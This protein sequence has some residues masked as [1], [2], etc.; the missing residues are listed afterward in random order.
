M[1]RNLIFFAGLLG[2]AWINRPSAPRGSRIYLFLAALCAGVCA[3]SAQGLP[4][5]LALTVSVDTNGVV[6]APTNFW[7]VN[8]N[9]MASAIS[10][11]SFSTNAFSVSGT[12][13]SLAPTEY[14]SADR[15]IDGGAPT[16][17]FTIQDIAAMSLEG[18]TASLSGQS[19][20]TLDGQQSLEIF[21]R[22]NLY[23][24]TPKAW[25]LEASGNDT[26][27]LVDASTGAVEYTTRDPA[28]V[29]ALKALAAS[30]YTDGAI[31]RTRGYYTAGDGGGATYRYSAS[32]SDAEDGAITLAP[33]HGTGRFKLVHDGRVSLKVFG[34]DGTVAKDTAA[35]S[36]A[37]VL[38]NAGTIRTI[39]IPTGDFNLNNNYS[40]TGNNITVQGDGVGSRLIANKTQ[41]GQTYLFRIYGSGIR[42]T[43]IAVKRATN[44]DTNTAVGYMKLWRLERGC[45]NFHLT[46]SH[47]DGN[48][49]GQIARS[50]YYYTEIDADGRGVASD[51]PNGIWILHNHFTG[52]TSRVMDFYAVR[53]AFVIGNY[54][55]TNGVSN[56]TGSGGTL[57]PGTCIQ[58]QSHDTAPS[59][60]YP[61]YGV[62]VMNNIA[63]YWGDG[64]C[65][66]A[67][68]YN[69]TIAGN[70][71]R[72]AGFLGLPPVSSNQSEN[73]IAVF[74]GGRGSITGNTAHYLDETAILLR[75]QSTAGN[76][77]KSLHDVTVSGNTC[78]GGTVLSTNLLATN[79]RV[80]ASD[81]TTATP[82][83]YHQN[84]NVVGNTV[85]T[86]STTQ[87]GLI[88]VEAGASSSLV[89]VN[90]S[91]NNLYGGGA[92]G[93][94][95]GVY[96]DLNATATVSGLKFNDN[97]MVD[98]ARGISLVTAT[99][100]PAGTHAV[101]NA[102]NNVGADVYNASS[103]A[104]ARRSL[105]R[106]TGADHIAISVAGQTPAST[107]VI[108]LP[109]NTSIQARNAGNTSDIN[110]IESTSSDTIR[111]S[112][113]LLNILPSTSLVRVGTTAKFVLGT[114][115][116]ASVT[117]GAT[118]S[119]SASSIL[120]VCSGG[121]VTLNSTTAITAGSE[122]GQLLLLTG[123]SDTDTVTV[124]NTGNMYIPSS[125]TLG[126]GDTLLIVYY[127]SGTGFNAGW[128]FVS[129]SNNPQ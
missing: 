92:G 68:V 31:F 29:S 33:S 74:G 23:L 72:G 17:D 79:I 1:K 21:G 101:N 127:G 28:S 63:E 73:G 65:N 69:F 113:G 119:P 117:A 118:L 97:L 61:C 19:S 55:G 128:R 7:T 12:S 103:S 126:R 105:L 86:D 108:R 82:A 39:Y 90:V 121:A 58:F 109:N 32:S 93:V 34:A 125:V 49:A 102:F 112:G 71:M 38:A 124:P 66:L 24:W 60:I 59:T 46:H 111:L 51:Q 41:S 94:T 83:V 2:M 26:L 89:G 80:L 10:Q 98:L 3:A 88:C 75:G 120:V 96:V 116:I 16:H 6:V 123:T 78:I 115:S 9:L 53:D 114:P 45:Q 18:V 20:L 5:A 84:I 56:Y 14:L 42:F 87:G 8:S 95:A 15:L 85:R 104:T 35:M 4:R 27:S 36:N 100:F 50:G 22:T 48:A 70:E 57:N 25:A 110:L 13:V 11:F 91:N 122:S 43:Q 129:S 64:F 37:V 99:T 67:G 44:T 106:Y 54:L 40:F 81:P 76:L 77:G 52:G 107:G 62:V 30:T 47:I